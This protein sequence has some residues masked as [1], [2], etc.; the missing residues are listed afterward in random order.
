MKDPRGK[1]CKRILTST[2]RLVETVI[3]QLTEQFNIEKVR[4]RT[5]WHLTSRITRKILAHTVGALIN[6]NLGN[7][8]LQFERLEIC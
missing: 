8:P 4:V 3:G 1:D 5:L 2:R 7:S 6:K